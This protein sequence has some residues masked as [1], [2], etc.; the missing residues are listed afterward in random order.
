ME[1]KKQTIETKVRSIKDK[2]SLNFRLYR[3]CYE[4]RSEFKKQLLH[5]SINSNKHITCNTQHNDST[6]ARY[7]S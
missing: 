6:C 2:C 1:V 7:L 3:S 5:F 4:Q